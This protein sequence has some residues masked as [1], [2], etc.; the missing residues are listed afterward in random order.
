MAYEQQKSRAFIQ[1]I[2]IFY[3]HSI[4]NMLFYAGFGLKIVLNHHT[5]QLIKEG[6]YGKSKKSGS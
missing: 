5:D 3:S 1:I 4:K 2:L 6:I